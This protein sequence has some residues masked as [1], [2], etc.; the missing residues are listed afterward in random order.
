MAQ[1]SH[2]YEEPFLILL[3][4]LA[5]GG[6]LWLFSTFIPA[7]LLA[8]L[9]ATAT[10]PFYQRLT[11][12]PY[13]SRDASALLATSSVLSLVIFPITYLFIEGGRMGTEV[14]DQ[15]QTWTQTHPQSLVQQL[16]QLVTLLPIPDAWQIK[17][18]GWIARDLTEITLKIQEIGMKI[19]GN[20]FS[21]ATSFVTFIAISLFSLFFFY[22]DGERFS[23]RI[24]NLSPLANH[25]DSFI[26]KR[27]A[28]LSTVLTISVL[29]VAV[30]Q[31]ITFG[32]LMW[33]LD[34]PALFLG[35]AFAIASFVP[36]VGGLLV[37]FPVAVYFLLTEHTGMAIFTMLYSL[38][39]IGF[40]IDN[41][42]RPMIIR[43]LAAW[44]GGNQS[45]NAILSHTW[46][47]M[48]STFAG[49]LHFGV[50][51]LMFGPML[52]AM[53]ITIFDVYEHKHRHQ[54]DYS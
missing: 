23:Q 15:W 5:V 41:L 49:L 28:D 9:L 44:R 18:Q 45:E 22:R 52:A 7:I 37:W 3:L 51:G 24:K 38:V 47:T 42:L 53:A 26:M 50:I 34:M 27:F 35:I 2:P 16:T 43:R 11:R 12:S 19:A 30:L 54:L 33:S 21:G 25:L 8:I 14:F 39:L 32:L 36:I 4:T 40:V 31:G 48:L 46:L 1:P 29:G 17:L 13:L 20:L 10:Y 6:L